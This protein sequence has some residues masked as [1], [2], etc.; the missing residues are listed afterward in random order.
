MP[1]SL[2]SHRLPAPLPPSTISKPRRKRPS[3]VLNAIQDRELKHNRVHFAK[4]TARERFAHL[5]HRVSMDLFV[6]GDSPPG[7]DLMMVQRHRITELC[8]AEGVVFGLTE[9]GVCACY[10]PRTGRRLCFLNSDASEVVRSLFHNKTSGTLITVSVFA[11]DNYACLRCKESRLAHLKERVTNKAKALFE[12]ESLR[13]PGFVE[14]DDVNGKVLTFSSDVNV[15]KVWSLPDPSQV[16][17]SFSDQTIPEGISEIKISPV[18]TAAQPR[19]P[20]RTMRAQFDHERRPRPTAAAR[21]SARD[22]LALSRAHGRA[23]C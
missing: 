12:T 14:F 21:L 23:S 2:R 1:I 6:A 8:A 18:R 7:I 13:W 22:S 16:L 20:T 4:R 11:S 17:Y 3:G 5:S 19:L 15:Y 10:C 9:N